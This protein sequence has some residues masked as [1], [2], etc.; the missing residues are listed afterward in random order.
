[1]YEFLIENV[2]RARHQFQFHTLHYEHINVCLT[3]RL[4]CSVVGKATEGAYCF[5][6][7]VCVGRYIH[8]NRG[9]TTKVDNRVPGWVKVPSWKVCTKPMGAASQKFKYEQKRDSIGGPQLQV[10]THLCV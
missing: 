8:S 9:P 2:L 6:P 3:S 1:M 4:L 7:W 10:F 5:T